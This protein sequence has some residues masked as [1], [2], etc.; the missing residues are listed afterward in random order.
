MTWGRGFGQAWGGGPLV[1]TEDPLAIVGGLPTSFDFT[2]EPNGPLPGLWETYVLDTDAAGAVVVSAEPDPPSRYKILDGLA[3]WNYARSP[4][5]PAPATAFQER[6]VAAGPSGVLVGRNAR[7][8]AILVSPVGLP[9]P[10]A[11]EFF[12][13]IVLG[14]RFDATNYSYVGGRVRARWAAGVWVEPITIE[15]VQATG[16]APSALATAP[17][18]DLPDNVDAWRASP[19]IE[20]A[21]TVSYDQ[22]D[23]EVNGVWQTSAT[24]P[25]DGQPKMVLEMRVYNRLGAFIAPIPVLAALSIQSLRDLERLGP[26]PQLPGDSLMESATLPMLQMPVQDLLDSGFLKRIG[27][28]RFQATQEFL[29]DVGGLS[30]TGGNRIL[31]REGEVLHARERFEGQALVPVT[32]DLAF[33]RGRGGL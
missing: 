10:K 24:I 31:V 32:R 13:E 3:L 23:V 6:G 9:N 7:V 28:R 16:Q 30:S 12:Y 33:Q 27:A 4:A 21:V 29:A 19:T 26:P 17:S 5:V 2:D 1:P 11:A 8:R 15:A 18:P 20:L 22:V 14:L 25:T